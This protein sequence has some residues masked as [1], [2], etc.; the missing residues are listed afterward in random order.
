MKEHLGRVV[1]PATWEDLGKKF[2]R[3]RLQVQFGVWKEEGL[4][5]HP[6]KDVKH[7]VRYGSLALR[8]QVMTF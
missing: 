5:R 4:V 6:S 8:S 1:P 3:G 7:A 2:L